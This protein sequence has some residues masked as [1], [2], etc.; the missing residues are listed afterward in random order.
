MAIS[1]P[2]K[3][4]PC[5]VAISRL[6]RSMASWMRSSS[7]FSFSHCSI[8]ARVGLEHGARFGQLVGRR[9][10]DRRHGRAAGQ[11]GGALRHLCADRAQLGHDLAMHRGGLFNYIWNGHLATDDILDTK[12][13][14]VNSHQETPPTSFTRLCRHKRFNT[15]FTAGTARRPRATLREEAINH[16]RAAFMENKR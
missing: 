13:F 12:T 1:P 14:A 2:S 3:L 6:V 5:S 11:W 16:G 15:K 8:C 7:T 10:V 4:L 9:G